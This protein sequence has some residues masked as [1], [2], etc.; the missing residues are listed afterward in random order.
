MQQQ[1]L[2][3]HLKTMIISGHSSVKIVL[4]I[5]SLSVLFA[6]C[7]KQNKKTPVLLKTEEATEAELMNEVNRFA[8]VNSMRAKMDL[9]FEDNSF[10]QFGSKEVYRSADGEVVVQRPANILLKVSA[11]KVDIAQM[12]S[13]GQSFRVAILN[14][15]GGDRCKKFVKGSNNADYSKLQKSLNTSDVDDKTLK[16][17][18][19]F[20]NL[21]PQHFTDAMLVRPIDPADVYSVSTIYQVEQE[22]ESGSPIRQVM[23]GYYLLDEFSKQADGTLRIIRRFWFDRV[24]GIRLARQQIFDAKAEIESDIVY[25]KEGNLTSS[26]EYK[27]LPLRVQ[28]TRPKE[29]YTMSLTYQT[30]EAVTIGKTYPATAFVLQNTWGF[31]EV[32]LDQKLQEINAARPAVNSNSVARPQ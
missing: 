3:R 8:R 7:I 24:G 1:Q 17:V 29:K 12:T 2:L 18:S 14:C 15:G 30:P 27:N 19:S 20:A 31:E 13:D 26:G 4:I 32:D 10:A 23:R 6:G 16:N 22:G 11:F 9:K 21:R 25:G 28:V 5:V